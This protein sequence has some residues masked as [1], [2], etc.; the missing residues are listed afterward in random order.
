MGKSGFL[1]LT[2]VLA[3]QALIGM[4]LAALLVM[5]EECG[6][7]V[8]MLANAEMDSIGM[9]HNVSA[10]HQDNIGTDIL[11]L[12]VLEGKSGVPSPLSANAKQGISGMEPVVSSFALLDR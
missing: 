6:I 2:L 4:D 12:A 11:V 1:P 7:A 10:A 3:S 8:L 9:A 5:V